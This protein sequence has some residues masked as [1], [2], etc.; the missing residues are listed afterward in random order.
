M[1]PGTRRR[2][3]VV[4]GGSAGAVEGLKTIAAGLPRDLPAA[5][6]TVV[7]IP[8]SA[9][10][11]LPQILTRVGALPAA[12]P[13]D[14]DP[15]VCGTITVGPPGRHLLVGRSTVHL[16]R[17]PREHGHRPAADVL[18]RSAARNHGA[19]VIGVVLSGMLGDGAAGLARVVERGGLGIVQDPSGAAFSSMP[20]RAVAAALPQHVVPLEEIAALI[21][22]AVTKEVPAEAAGP[23]PGTEEDEEPEMEHTTIGDDQPGRPTGFSCPECGGV[24]WEHHDSRVME[25]ICRIGHRYSLESLLEAKESALEG[26][27]W[28]GV[29]A[30]EEH[31]SLLRRLAAG[32]PPQDGGPH[33]RFTE[34]AEEGEHQVAM[35]RSLLERRD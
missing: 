22:E 34:R 33:E 21:V 25:A 17:G 12:H 3:I 24:L 18:F 13:A 6:F 23:Q 14:G 27:M 11:A 16:S 8:S 29:R 5:V 35:L 2:D 1:S 7:H 9:A 30:L 31:V 4:I 20:E 10:S 26:A 15:L 28:A 19:A 32:H